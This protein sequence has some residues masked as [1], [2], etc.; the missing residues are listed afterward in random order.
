VQC[1][2]QNQRGGLGIA[3]REGAAALAGQRFEGHH[4]D[5]VRPHREPGSGRVRLDHGAK[6]GVAQLGPQP[7]HQRLQR[8]SGISWRVVWPDLPGQRPRRHDTPG[9]QRQQGQQNAQLTTADNQ[10][11]PIGVLHVKRAK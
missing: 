9:V 5:R 2:P 1:V 4:V 8:V 6:P 11:A 3:V 7:G 10:R